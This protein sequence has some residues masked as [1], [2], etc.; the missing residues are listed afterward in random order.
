[1][2]IARPEPRGYP[3]NLGLLFSEHAQSDRPAIIELRDPKQPRPVSFRELDAGCNAVARG[4]TR[5]GLKRGDRIGILSLNRVEFVS[6]LL[7]AMR[8]GVVPVPVNVKLAPDAVAY[9]LNDAGARM[10]F[11]ERDAKRL[12]PAGIR[13]VEF[14]REFEQFADPGPFTAIEP[15]PDSIAI[16]PYT[17]GSTGRPK[18]AVNTHGAVCNRLSWMQEAF[19]LD[20]S[21]AVLQKTPFS[22]DVSVW[23]F[24]WPL[25]TGARLVVARPRGH[26]DGAYLVETIRREGIT[27]LH[28]VP[29]MLQAFVEQPGLEGCI[30]LRRVICSGEALGSD[31]CRRFQARLEVPL[32]NL[33]GPTEAAI[34]VT[35]QVWDSRTALANVPIGHPIANTRV[36]VLD[37][38]FRPVPL[39][40]LGHLHLGGVQLARCYL[41]RPELTAERF[42][43]DPFSTTGGERLYRTGDLARWLPDGRLEFLGRLDHQVKVRGFR[44]ELGEIEAALARHPAV[45]ETVVTVRED[46]PGDRRLVAYVVATN[47]ERLAAPQ[48]RGFLQTTLPDYMV[49]AAFLFLDALPLSPNGKLDRRALPAPGTERPDLEEAYVPP[50]SEIERTL[51]GLWLEVLKVERVGVRDNFF[52]LGGDSLLLLRLHLKICSLFTTDLVITDLFRYPTISSLAARLSDGETGASS[53]EEGDLRAAARLVLSSQRTQLRE[54][55]RSARQQERGSDG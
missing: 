27:T 24:F 21:D 41:R 32:Y 19:G 39:G 13:V 14:G 4:L 45:R 26:Q 25:M 44:I 16:Q 52:N 18:G 5:A 38:G 30:S 28:F 3:G 47:G 10:V 12:I 37:P 17:S 8:A 7:G 49:P 11:A 43:P 34:D 6:T 48:L 22:F 29:S 35:A 9:I 42:V 2:T 53:R 46:T 33:Y 55:R 50:Q 36:Y 23:E 54:Q 1:M 51:A 15:A 31:L 20:G 40:A